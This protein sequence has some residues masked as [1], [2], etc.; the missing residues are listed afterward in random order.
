MDYRNYRGDLPELP[1]CLTR[2]LHKLRWLGGVM[3]LS[4][5]VIGWLTVLKI[6]QISFFWYIL[7]GLNMFFGIILFSIGLVF[8]NPI[9][10]SK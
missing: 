7:A 6:I 5:P 3:V 2:H 8:D 1:P 10:R 9:D 4:T